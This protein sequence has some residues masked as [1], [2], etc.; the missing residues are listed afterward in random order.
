[1]ITTVTPMS[2]D[3]A[4]ALAIAYDLHRLLGELYDR[5]DGGAGSPIE[6]AW[7][8]MDDVIGYLEPEEWPGFPEGEPS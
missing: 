7:N 6:F 4:R 1:M 3:H 2:A 5:P 8:C